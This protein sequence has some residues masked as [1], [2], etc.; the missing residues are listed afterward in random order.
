MRSSHFTNN[1]IIGL[2]FSI[3]IIRCRVF[4]YFIF[5]L[6]TV[7]LLFQELLF[8]VIFFLLVFVLLLQILEQS[9]CHLGHGRLLRAFIQLPQP[10]PFDSVVEDQAELV[11]LNGFE[12]FLKVP[13]GWRKYRVN[14]YTEGMIQHRWD[15]S[16]QDGAAIYLKA[17]VGVC[18]DQVHCKVL[19]YHKVKAK[20]LKRI[21]TAMGV[22]LLVGNRAEGLCHQMAHLR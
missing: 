5:L 21:H 15:H 14:S 11:L 7:I 12:T 9:L 19:I 1:S 6:I 17:W 20:D 18:F 2:P 16:R 3:I 22:N 13:V 10:V 4:H 8:L